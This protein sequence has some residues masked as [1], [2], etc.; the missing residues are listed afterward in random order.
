MLAGRDGVRSDSDLLRIC[1]GMRAYV[2]IQRDGVRS[3]SDL[4]RVS[5]GVTAYVQAH[6]MAF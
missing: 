3:D 5:R 2:Q 4:L 1:R 6:K